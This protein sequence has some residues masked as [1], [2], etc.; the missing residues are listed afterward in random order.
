ML[1][2][3]S[4]D[5]RTILCLGAHADDI[6]IGCGGTLLDLLARRPGV[7]V[8]WIVLSACGARADEAAASAERF[9]AG[10]GSHRVALKSFR[11]TFFP[12]QYGEIKEYFEKIKRDVRP[13]LVFTHRREDAHQDHRVTAELTWCGFRNHLVLEYEIPKYEGDLG[14]PNVF[15]PLEEEVCRRKIELL[16]ECYPSQHAAHPWFSP[17]T[18]RALLRLR[19]VECN[20]PTGYAEGLYARKITLAP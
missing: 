6:E 11:D 14:A 16:M 4:E 1:T 2:L 20:S 17:D 9:C 8:H 12:A 7:E 3:R 19:G 10:A 15:V 18:Y 13:D 5:I